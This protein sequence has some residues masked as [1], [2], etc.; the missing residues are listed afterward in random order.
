MRSRACSKRR[1]AAASS[2]MPAHEAVAVV[3]AGEEQH[4]PQHVEHTRGEKPRLAARTRATMTDAS[5]VRAVRCSRLTHSAARGRRRASARNATPTA[6]GPAACAPRSSRRAPAARSRCRQ[7]TRPVG[8]EALAQRA[9]RAS[10]VAAKRVGAD[11]DQRAAPPASGVAR[12]GPRT[13]RQSGDR[14]T[15]AGTAG[16]AR[17]PA[18]ASAPSRRA[19]RRAARRS[20]PPCRRASAR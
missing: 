3:G 13:A 18:S 1:C 20:A 2:T 8:R 4:L 14:Q 19:A 9:P 7:S 11:R 6:I 5:N 17:Q 12:R 10:R 16:R 15:R